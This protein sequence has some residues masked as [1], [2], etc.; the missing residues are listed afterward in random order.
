[1]KRSQFFLRD[2]GMGR[3]RLLVVL[4]GIHLD[5]T[6]RGKGDDYRLTWSNT[7]TE[8]IADLRRHHER[9]DV[10]LSTYDSPAVP[11]LKRVFQPVDALLIHGHW[12]EHG[13][14][15]CVLN[16]L[17][18][19]S[20]RRSEYDAA[21][22]HRF[23]LLLHRPWSSVGC[24]YDKVN[25]LWRERG[26]NTK[27]PDRLWR[28]HMRVGDAIMV[29]PTRLLDE[30][31]AAVEEVGAA[32]VLN[33]SDNCHRLLWHLKDRVDVAADV[34]ILFDGYYDSDPA[35]MPN[36]AYDEVDCRKT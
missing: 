1:M 29:F 32:A 23:D 28:D 8:M 15:E 16:A 27:P 9:V 7:A 17:R 2:D 30:C 12:R 34:N 10:L 22:V 24:D 14:T 20:G 35:R 36:P 4:R 11:D 19:L 25:F 21:I 5:R 13:K 33:V 18:W 31:V 3:R 26:L 6:Y